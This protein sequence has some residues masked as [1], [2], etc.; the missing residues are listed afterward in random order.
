M[1]HLHRYAVQTLCFWLA[2]LTFVRAWD[3]A[4]WVKGV[5][6]DVASGAIEPFQKIDLRIVLEKAAELLPQIDVKGIEKEFN[7][8]GHQF[9]KFE[10]QLSS[11]L[12]E[13]NVTLDDFVRAFQKKFDSQAEDLQRVFAENE[14]EGGEDREPR[15]ALEETIRR[16]FAKI[17][18]IS[19]AVAVE[20]GL[21]PD[22]IRNVVTQMEEPIVSFAMFIAEQVMKHPCLF[23]ILPLFLA[24]AF[25]A[26]WIFRTIVTSLGFGILG[27]IKGSIAAKLQSFIFGAAVPKGS[28]F[29]VMQRFGM[30]AFGA[31]QVVPLSML[32]ALATC[33]AKYGNVS[34]F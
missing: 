33:Y 30:S 4:D 24:A 10:E 17:Q 14:Q 13:Q 28:W 27:P 19:V 31:T 6:S 8:F 5:A 26:Y 2:L 25:P 34:P 12:R 32:A 20:L 22:S 1:V 15:Q 9:A 11:V 16:I 18:D 23:A 3:P 7:N 29:A 21:D